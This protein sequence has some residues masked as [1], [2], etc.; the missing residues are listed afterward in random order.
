MAARMLIAGEWVEAASGKTYTRANPATGEPVG[1]V[2]LGDER[3]AEHAVAAAAAAFPGWRATP[4]TE[5]A[6][7]LR[8]T[9]GVLRAR[10][11][12]I[13][14]LITSEQGKPIGAARAEVLAAAELLDWYAEEARRV[15]GE[16]IPDPLPDRRLLTVRQ[17]IGVAAAITPW[18]VPVSMVA[19]KAGAALA[20]ACAVVVKPAEQTPLSALAVA[21]AFTEAGLPPGA[22]NVVT[23]D[24]ASIGGVLLGDDRVRA[25]SFTGSTATG[26]L[27]MR[28]AAGTVK[29][30]S[31]ELGGNAPFVIFDDA[32]LDLAVA[33][34]AAVKF[35]NA[36]QTCVSPNRVFVH[37]SVA[38]AVTAR[39]TR[40]VRSLHVGNGL[41]PEAQVG[42]LVDHAALAKVERHVA[43]ALDR[44]ARLE[45]G[46]RRLT[47]GEYDGG[48]F[49]EPTVLS[50]VDSSMLIATEETFGPVAGLLTFSGEDEVVAAANATPYGLASY[51]YTR[52]LGRAFR[53]AEGIEAGMVGVNDT[54]L[55]APE[56]PFG[57]VKHSGLGRE[58]GRQGLDEF[59]ETKL[60][61]IGI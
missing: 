36:G 42:P 12:D 31:L 32:D 52:D 9:G 27:L 8:R 59:L 24:P 1:E 18:N 40:S 57:G 26:M 17:P 51:V 4:V 6:A 46:G 7:A 13:A 29:K 47:G 33:A 61:T 54:R 45:T 30:L 2:P 58:G 41:A 11:A 5:R 23:G 48:A 34:L 25:V 43:D 39:L 10:V 3:D 56:A 28:Q 60:I 55:S 37:E 19:R 16:W 35:R 14:R 53:V 15:Y 22:V 44:G 38:E 50:H 20:A 21:E 49:Y